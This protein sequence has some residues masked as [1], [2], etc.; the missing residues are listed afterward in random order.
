[1]NR[2][3]G[4]KSSVKRRAESELLFLKL[5]LKVQL[6]SK[7]DEDCFVAS[8]IEGTSTHIEQSS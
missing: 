6:S 4:S 1:M 3:L 2:N 5:I 7:L 8:F